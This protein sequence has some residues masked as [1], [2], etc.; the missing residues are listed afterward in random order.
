MSKEVKYPVIDGQ[1]KRYSLPRIY[2]VLCEYTDLQHHLKQVDIIR[3]VEKLYGLKLERKIVADKVS[4]LN[5]LG[6]NY[7]IQI[8][9]DDGV[10]MGSRRLD[11]GEVSFLIDAVFSSRSISQKEAQALTK[12]LQ[13]FLS[14]YERKSFNYVVKGGELTRT[15]NKMVFYNIELLLDAIEQGKKIKFH[16]NRFYIDELKNKEKKER[17]LIANPY[18][19]VNNQGRYYLVCN[20]DYYDDIANYRV[21]RM[22][23]IEILPDD[24]KPLKSLKGCEKFDIIEYAKENIYMFSSATIDAKVAIYDEYSVSYVQDWYGDNARIYKDSSGAVFADIH[25]NEQA[26]IYWCLQYGENIELLEPQSTREKI[27]QII[28]KMENNYK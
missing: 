14:V 21:E 18:H 8:G 23:D 26:L 13:S 28:T 16:Y 25:A 24:V 27:K 12:K 7:G 15:D 19:L 9:M 3:K 2:E 11:K 1:N 22:S 5:Y 4:D 20:N 6:K 17:W 10:Y